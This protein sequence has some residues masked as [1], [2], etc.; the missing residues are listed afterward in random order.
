[1]RAEAVARAAERVDIRVATARGVENLRRNRG[2]QRDAIG[3]SID[4]GSKI[5]TVVAT[6]TFCC[7]Y[8]CRTAVARE[9]AAEAQT[10]SHDDLRATDCNAFA[11]ASMNMPGVQQLHIG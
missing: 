10:G 7:R 8:D 6:E 4:P 2:V 9:R 11:C 3:R 1:M 5:G